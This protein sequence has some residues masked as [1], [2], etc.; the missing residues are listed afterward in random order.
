MELLL[1]LLWLA[2]AFVALGVCR[3]VSRW[4]GKS[5]RSRAFVLT[6][7]LLA[8]VF[9]VVSA[10]DDLNALRTGDGGGQSKRP[11]R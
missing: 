10:S 11:K 4:S 1:N 2:L 6:C 7:C 5:N 8:L 3:R 9:P